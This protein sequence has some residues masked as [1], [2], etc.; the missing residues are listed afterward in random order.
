MKMLA[1]G[2]RRADEIL[3]GVD[4]FWRKCLAHRKP[5]GRCPDCVAKA[6]FLRKG[7]RLASR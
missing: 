3:L 4:E 6:A 2:Y 5:L 1:M 7:W